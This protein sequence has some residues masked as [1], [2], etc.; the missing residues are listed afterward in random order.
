[1]G[2]AGICSPNVQ[3]NSDA[4]YHAKSIKEIKNELQSNS[5]HVVISFVNQAPVVSAL[6]NYSIPISTPFILTASAT[7]GEGDP[8]LLLLGTV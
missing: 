8:L 4:Y 7:D 3:N 1:M 5:C 2:Y 6:T